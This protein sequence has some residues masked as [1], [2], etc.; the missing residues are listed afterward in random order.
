MTWLTT[1]TEFAETDH[2]VLRT[3]DGQK[4]MDS[5]HFFISALVE[6]AMHAT[7]DARAASKEGARIL[8]VVRPVCTRDYA[9]SNDGCNFVPL[10][11][12]THVSVSPK[13]SPHMP[14][15]RPYCLLSG[16]LALPS[17]STVGSAVRR[18]SR[19]LQDAPL[20][21]LA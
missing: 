11:P 2:A 18:W 21:R 16:F 10:H 15:P 8:G 7:H 13:R 6:S 12:L 4:A 5:N 3:I 1:T 20:S 17:H 9:G 19:Q 14:V